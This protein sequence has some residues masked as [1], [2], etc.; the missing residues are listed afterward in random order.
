MINHGTSQSLWTCELVPLMHPLPNTQIER[1]RE[2]ER[3]REI[4]I[5]ISIYPYPVCLCKTLIVHLIDCVSCLQVYQL[6]CI[7]FS[8]QLDVTLSLAWPPNWHP[9]I[10]FRPLFLSTRDTSPPCHLLKNW[11]HRH[12][13]LRENSKTLSIYSE[14][15]PDPQRLLRTLSYWAP[16]LH[17]HLHGI[18]PICSQ[19]RIT[20]QVL[21]LH[22]L[23]A[24]ASIN[25]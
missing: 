1:E 9:W 22:H 24:D 3:E 20:S 6:C 18:S 4:H 5:V 21:L 15:D 12:S 11:W 25:F 16:A 10:Y 2:R 7:A 17:I 23:L 14:H 13:T 8:F 19:P